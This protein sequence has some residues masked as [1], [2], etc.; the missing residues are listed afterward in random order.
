MAAWFGFTNG[1]SLSTA[2]SGGARVGQGWDQGEASGRHS[3]KET[4]PLRSAR[5]PPS[6]PWG[7]LIGS[8]T[9]CSNAS[10]P[11]YTATPCQFLFTTVFAEFPVGSGTYLWDE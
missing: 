4:L 5:Q 10:L 9:I 2:L 6:Q 8:V 7:G 1:V 3:F 11:V